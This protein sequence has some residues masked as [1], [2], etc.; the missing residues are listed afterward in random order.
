MHRIF[1][2]QEIQNCGKFNE[3]IT[4]T[5]CFMHLISPQIYAIKG[6]ARRRTKQSHKAH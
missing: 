1:T 6:K 2:E 4:Y 5:P 3:C